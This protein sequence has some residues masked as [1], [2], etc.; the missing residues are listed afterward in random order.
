MPRAYI[1]LDGYRGTPKQFSD[2]GSEMGVEKENP[3]Q[4]KYMAL[5]VDGRALSEA[6]CSCRSSRSLSDGGVESH[7]HEDS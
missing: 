1:I 4:T 7:M 5:Q 2:F 6:D 3:C